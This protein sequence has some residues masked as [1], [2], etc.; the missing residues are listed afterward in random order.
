M[1]ALQSLELAAPRTKLP[2]LIQECQQAVSAEEPAELAADASS[3]N[4][5]FFFEGQLSCQVSKA[6]FVDCIRSTSCV[7]TTTERP[8]ADK[9]PF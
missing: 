8:R 5:Q 2:A 4:R 6:L 7:V 1:C 9:L 3:N